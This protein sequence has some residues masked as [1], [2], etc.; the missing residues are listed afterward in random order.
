VQLRAFKPLQALQAPTPQHDHVVVMKGYLHVC[1]ANPQ[2]VCTGSACD[3]LSV[4]DAGME[5]DA[6]TCTCCSPLLH[7]FG[8]CASNAAP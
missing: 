4:A 3:M 1:L 6:K 8:T 5:L 7:A 2:T